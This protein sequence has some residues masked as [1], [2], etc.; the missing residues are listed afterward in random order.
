MQFRSTLPVIMALILALMIACQAPTQTEE[1]PVSPSPEEESIS[2]EAPTEAGEEVEPPADPAEISEAVA[3]SINL[4]QPPLTLDPVGVAPLDASGGDLAEGLFG[5]LTRLDTDRGLT[6]PSFA[7]EWEVSED[8]LTWIIHLRD[9]IFW[10]GVNPDSGEVEQKRPIMAADVV[11]AA[12]RACQYDTHAPMYL[13]AMVIK[14]CEQIYAQD[15]AAITPEFIEQHFG[16][17]V[18][19]D[20]TVEFTLTGPPATFPT[21]MAMPILRPVPFDLVE[22]KRENWAQ[23]ENIWTSGPYAIQPGGDSTS[24]YQL[25][26]NPYWPFDREGNVEAITVAFDPGTT[27]DYAL[28]VL[29]HDQIPTADSINPQLAQPAGS[30]IAFSYDTYPF[31]HVGIRQAFALS[32]DRQAIIEQVLKPNGITGVPAYTL[33]PPGMASAPY[34]GEV[35]AHFDPDAAH[36]IMGETGFGECLNMPSVT[37]LTDTSPLS[38]ALAEAYVAQWGGV[39]NCSSELFVIEQAPLRDVLD[40][41]RQPPGPIERERPGLIMF[42]WQ[43]DSLDAHPWLTDVIGCQELYPEAYLDQVRECLPAEQQLTTAANLQDGEARRQIYTD[44]ENAFFGPEGDMPLIPIYFTTRPLVLQE[45]L[46]LRPPWLD[47]MPLVYSGP[48]Q[49]DRWVVLSM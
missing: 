2:I 6:T 25:V 20:V 10:V 8:G 34:Y 26:S 49:F 5:G 29:P 24:G 13:S 30:Y 16:A 42:S 19:N 18:L 41:L 12:V 36:R 23:P 47:F 7:R 43:A 3:V 48:L 37:I 22:S 1:Q 27:G 35:G 15:T 45:S 14:G 33:I 39:L 11:Y 44:V 32:I 4:G 21:L 31:S 40:T 46:M 17:K 28:S 9:D 38:L